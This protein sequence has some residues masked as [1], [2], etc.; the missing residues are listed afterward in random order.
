MY[1]CICAQDCHVHINV[2]FIAGLEIMVFLPFLI[3]GCVCYCI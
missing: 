3:K 2:V 1:I